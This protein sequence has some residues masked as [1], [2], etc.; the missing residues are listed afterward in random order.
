[1][2][3]TQ[4]HPIFQPYTMTSDGPVWALAWNEETACWDVACQF[5]QI[6][7]SCDKN[8]PAE[9]QMRH[10]VEV[11]A[12]LNRAYGVTPPSHPSG[13]GGILPL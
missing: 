6:T 2:Y 5:V 10:A 8:T 3:G 4:H 1:M 11:C 9:V 12:A 7:V 13:D